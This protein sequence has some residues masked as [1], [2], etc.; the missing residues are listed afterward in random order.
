MS[1]CR[2]SSMWC[3]CRCSLHTSIAGMLYGS[4]RLV[5]QFGHGMN[6]LFSAIVQSL[7]GSSVA[8]N[9]RPLKRTISK[10]LK[11]NQLKLVV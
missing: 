2:P 1:I 9:I 8:Q 11:R 4:G 7:E 6:F 3:K 10:K 5:L